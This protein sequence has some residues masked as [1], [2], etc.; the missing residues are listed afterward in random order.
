MNT[1][2][3]HG[4]TPFRLIATNAIVLQYYALNTNSRLRFGSTS[5]PPILTLQLST[6]SASICMAG[7]IKVST[8]ALGTETAA[9]G[10]ASLKLGF[11]KSKG[12]S[13]ELVIS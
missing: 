5:I 4:A 9:V 1:I 2:N 11:Y 7:S 13:S 6:Q 10:T 3:S 8:S 12:S